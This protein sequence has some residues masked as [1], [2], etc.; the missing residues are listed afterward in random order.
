MGWGLGKHLQ[1]I[2]IM[3]QL[4][5][6]ILVVWTVNT[7][8]RQCYSSGQWDLVMYIVILQQQHF[9]ASMA[10]TVK[11]GVFCVATSHILV[12]GYQSSGGT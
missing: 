4:M 8:K 1:N 5:V 6:F 9:G 2:Y 3:G 10:V 12:G 7:I 11:I